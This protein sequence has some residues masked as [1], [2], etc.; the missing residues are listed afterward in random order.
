VSKR[1][2]CAYIP[3]FPIELLIREKPQLASKPVALSDDASGQD[4]IIDMNEKAEKAGVCKGM[5]P[6]QAHSVC[7][8][9]V[10]KA[11]DLK[12]EMRISEGILKALQ[13]VSPSVQEEEPGVYFVDTS[14][15][16]LLYKSEKGLANK[17]ISAIRAKLYPVRVGI[18]KNKFLARV[19]AEISQTSPFTIITAGTEK[20][21]LKDIPTDYLNIS[22]EVLD[23]LEDLGI[24]TIGEISDFNGN[25]MALRFKSEGTNLSL[26]SK[27]SDPELFSPETLSEKLSRRVVLTYSIDRTDAIISHIEKL[28]DELF[29]RLK[30]TGHTADRILIH[31]RL[32]DRTDISFDVTLDKPTVNTRKFIR[33]AKLELGKQELLSGVNEIRLTIP[34]TLPQISEQL[35]L[36]KRTSNV[37]TR[38]N[39]VNI[40]DF[41]KLCFPEIHSSF[42]PERN[43]HLSP[44]SS[45]QRRTNGSVQ[46]TDWSHPY[47]MH[48][49]SGLRLLQPPK[50]A[51][52][53][54]EDGAPQAI[55]LGNI[56]QK[57]KKRQGPWQ[58]SGE[59]WDKGF[60]RLY[61]EIETS[62]KKLYLLFYDRLSSRWYIHGIFD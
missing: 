22:G 39:I 58:I 27:G 37:L 5:T 43:F 14:G 23:R 44:V 6:P 29:G 18:A 61:Y 56:S 1:V 13:E 45:S 8:K 35:E 42:L 7:S 50:V 55:V 48:L 25:E 46:M 3:N 40:P 36:Q 32:E 34:R 28:L 54:T 21:F 49:I 10:I 41:R 31:L 52:V 19:A 17:I 4:T 12:R 30:K 9:L 26:R 59:W 24:K 2:A 38:E 57:I 20:K 53:V 33:Q 15:L 47:A 16:T 11:S 51:T 62:D 60:D